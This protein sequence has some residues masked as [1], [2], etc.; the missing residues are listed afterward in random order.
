MTKAILLAIAGACTALALPAQAQI[1][2]GEI[3]DAESCNRYFR[4]AD[5]GGIDADGERR[6]YA[7]ELTRD[8]YILTQLNQSLRAAEALDAD[9]L[10]VRVDDRTVTLG[11][12][13]KDAETRREAIALAAAIP[14]V[15]EVNADLLWVEGSADPATVAALPPPLDQAAAEDSDAQAD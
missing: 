1:I 12:F 9:T 13:M 14:G 4:G 15:Q 10:T 8:E 2:H 7:V 3:T 5:G 11:G 6:L